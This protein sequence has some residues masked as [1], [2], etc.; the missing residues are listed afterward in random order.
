VNRILGIAAISNVRSSMDGPCTDEY[1]NVTRERKE[2]KQSGWIKKA[3]AK[4][5]EDIDTPKI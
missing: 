2:L 4:P 5:T 3:L 1:S